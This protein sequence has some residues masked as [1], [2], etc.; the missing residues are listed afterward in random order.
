M[1]VFEIIHLNAGFPEV[2]SLGKSILHF[3]S[4]QSKQTEWRLHSAP[5]FPSSR[6]C[7]YCY[8][9][10]HLSTGLTLSIGL[11]PARVEWKD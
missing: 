9:A 8:L 2:V 1:Y 11:S 4:E 3:P 5:P 6:F 10:Q 7:K